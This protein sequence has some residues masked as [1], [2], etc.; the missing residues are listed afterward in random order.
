MDYLWSVSGL[1]LREE[2]SEERLQLAHAVFKRKVSV[3][4][5]AA[6]EEKVSAYLKMLIASDKTCWRT[7]RTAPDAWT[8]TGH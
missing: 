2:G 6:N 5:W 8:R 3:M 7:E 4:L 1:D